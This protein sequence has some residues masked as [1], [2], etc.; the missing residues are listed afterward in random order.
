MENLVK[1]DVEVEVKHSF[2]ES[3]EHY[4]KFRQSWKQ[5]IAD[6]KHKCGTYPTSNGGEAKYDSDLT[7]AHHLIYNALRKRDL[8]KSFSPITRETKLAESYGNPYAAYDAAR[9]RISYLARS[10]N[11]DSLAEPFGGTI[12][13]EM[14][15]ELS[16]VLKTIEL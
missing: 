9:W 1:Q 3:K 2:F 8:S 7:C 11:L 4:L 5:Y 6:G 16:E 15:Q 10:G 13:K 14:L 12:S